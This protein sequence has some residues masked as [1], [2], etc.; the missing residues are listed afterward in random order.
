MMVKIKLDI[1]H[2][3]IVN[4]WASVVSHDD[5]TYDAWFEDGSFDSCLHFDAV[6]GMFYGC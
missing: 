6:R 4:T 3:E 1:G 5:D 2:G